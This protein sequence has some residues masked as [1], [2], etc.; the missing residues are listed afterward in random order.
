MRVLAAIGVLAIV[1]AIAAAAFFFG[2]F[3]SVAA[4]Q[5]QPGIV[6]SALIRVRQASI[7]RHA[8]ETPPLSLVDV[9]VVQAG[10]RAFAQ[11]GCTN[12]HGGPG[13]GWAKFSEGLNPGPPDLKEIVDTIEPRQLFWVIKNGIDMTGMPSFGAIEVPDKEIW[14]IVAFLKKLPTVSDQDYKAWTAPASSGTQ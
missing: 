14:T 12:C 1:V 3:Y 8:V 7:N 5:P 10:A 13:V 9:A 2:G 6:A 11:R 4:S